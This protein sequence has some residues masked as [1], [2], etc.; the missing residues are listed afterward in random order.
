MN[1]KIKSA[2]IFFSVL[3]IILETVST[4]LKF[5]VKHSMAGQNGK[6]NLVMRHIVD[7]KIVFFGSSVAEVGIN[8]ANIENLTNLGCYNLGINAT[9]FMQYKSLI[10]EFN[11]YSD[12]CQY[13]IVDDTYSMFSETKNIFLLEH[14]VSYVGNKNV[15]KA[16]YSIQPDLI[17]KTRYVPFYKFITFSNSYYKDAF[18]GW[19]A[20]FGRGKSVD[21]L[22]GFTPCYQEWQKSVENGNQM[23]IRVEATIDTTSVNEF[24]RLINTVNQRHR[25]MVLILSPIQTEGQQLIAG[26]DSLK[27]LL[28]SLMKNGNIFIDGCTLE[29]CKDKKY[30]Y[31]NTHLNNIGASLFS[32]FI[33]AKLD[34]LVSV[35]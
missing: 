28:N 34:S 33:G 26:L 19:K 11:E 4:L 30:F 17:W 7:K 3:L 23:K 5:G 21:T 18:L 32:N 15:Y 16:L 1:S 24:K 10:N 13:I 35:N 29:L 25:K 12:S 6:V 2:I 22:M 20:I 8:P 9:K 31:N 27:L 14:F